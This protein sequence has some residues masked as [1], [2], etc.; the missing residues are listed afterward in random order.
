MRL[1]RWP[2]VAGV[3]AGV[4]TVCCGGSVLGLVW[5]AA[6]VGVA[7]G[8]GTHPLQEGDG[9]ERAASDAWFGVSGLLGGVGAVLVLFAIYQLFQPSGLVRFEDRVGV[10]LAVVG[11]VMACALA[12]RAGGRTLRGEG[13]GAAVNTA[14]AVPGSWSC[15]F[16]G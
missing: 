4:L 9:W 3:V 1:T 5:I 8:R 10:S 12:A 2:I 16:W 7:L 11:V 13:L 6:G 14:V 15:V